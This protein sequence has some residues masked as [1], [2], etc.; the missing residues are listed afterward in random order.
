MNNNGTNIIDRIK[1]TMLLL[2]FIWVDKDVAMIDIMLSKEKEWE[3]H[4]IG[5]NLLT[6]NRERAKEVTK[7]FKKAIENMF[8]SGIVS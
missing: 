8:W 5:S 2:G 1:I 6:V 7:S 3:H 4:I